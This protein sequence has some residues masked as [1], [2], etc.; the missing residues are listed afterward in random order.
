[1]VKVS[2][3][4]RRNVKTFLLNLTGVSIQ[5]PFVSAGTCILAA[6]RALVSRRLTKPAGLRIPYRVQGFLN[7]PTDQSAHTIL[8]LVIIDPDHFGHR[9]LRLL[10]THL[11][12]PSEILKGTIPKNQ[13][14]ERL[15]TLS[16][17]STQNSKCATA[18]KDWLRL[19]DA[20][21]ASA[22]VARRE[23]SSIRLQRTEP[24]PYPHQVEAARKE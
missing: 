19:P 5:R 10:V 22:A 23:S 15:C 18:A 1:M 6:A 21:W 24:L 3:V 17:F 16:V 11:S 4:W 13:M 12:L 14:C 8:D 20:C 2:N 7:D 9:S